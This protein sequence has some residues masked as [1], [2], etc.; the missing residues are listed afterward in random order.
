M[1][2]CNPQHKDCPYA[3]GDVYITSSATDPATRWPGTS[4][5]RISG[6][7]LWG[8]DDAHPNNTTG[9]SLTHGHGLNGTGYAAIGNYNT[10]TYFSNVGAKRF[11]ELNPP[12]Q[13][14][15]EHNGDANK[16]DSSPNANYVAMT[17]LYGEVNLTTQIQPYA[18]RN[19]WE[20]TA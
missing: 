4:W 18:S 10:T 11:A 8:A 5:K 1:I 7:F 9:G 17:S 2:V 19:I 14:Y 3:V 6:C 15:W 20:R 16:T 12:D 13:Y